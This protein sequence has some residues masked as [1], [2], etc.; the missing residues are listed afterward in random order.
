MNVTFVYQSAR[1]AVARP[2]P[3]PGL[4]GGRNHRLRA[5]FG[6][7]QAKAPAVAC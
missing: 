3:Q 7:Q 1:V 2:I 4:V 5:T 6:G